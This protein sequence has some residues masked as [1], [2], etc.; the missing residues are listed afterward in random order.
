MTFS[1]YKATGKFF[2]MAFKNVP[3][4]T[5]DEDTIEGKHTSRSVEDTAKLSTRIADTLEGGEVIV[6]DGDLGAGKTTFTKGLAEALG[7]KDQ[8][9]SPTFTIMNVYEDGKFKLNHLDMYR[10]ENEDELHEL[11]VED[12][13]TEDTIT[14]IE[15]NK[16]SLEGTK[17]IKINIT[18]DKNKRIFTVNYENTCS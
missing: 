9:T 8:V 1:L 4:K 11:G 15:W 2:K 14:V 16:L 13:M 18:T 5:V 17:V 7:I 3:D 6:L 10:I 12:A